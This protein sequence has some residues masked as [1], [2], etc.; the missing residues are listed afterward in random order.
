MW[1]EGI[2]QNVIQNQGGNLQYNTIRGHQNLTKFWLLSKISQDIRVINWTIIDIPYQKLFSK[3]LLKISES[4]QSTFRKSEKIQSKFRQNWKNTEIQ[5]KFRENS[6]KFQRSLKIDWKSIENEE[7]IQTKFRGDSEGFQRDLK[8]DWKFRGDS[9][10][11]QCWSETFKRI[12]KIR[13]KFRGD[14]VALGGI[15]KWK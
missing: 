14:Q 6:N 11:F 13:S 7:R 9:E 4:R 2:V 5:R 3:F 8:I 15:N 12:W 1:D 10:G